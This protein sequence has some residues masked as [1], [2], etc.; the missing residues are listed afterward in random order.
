MSRNRRNQSKHRHYGNVE[1]LARELIYPVDLL[2]W[3]PR[4]RAH[5][6]LNERRVEVN[7]LRIQCF[8]EKGL[9]CANCSLEA[10]FAALE[11]VQSPNY[12]GWALNFYGLRDGVEIIFTK[13]H[14]YPRSKGGPDEMD[15]LQPM[16]WPCNLR[17]GNNVVQKVVEG[18]SR[19]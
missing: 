16:C 8:R 15:N 4:D 13:D 2:E 5:M 9:T 1:L 6:I 19:S 18:H 17:K 10:S 11:L 7:N 14:I 3:M 12:N